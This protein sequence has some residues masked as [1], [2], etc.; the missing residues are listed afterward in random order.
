M[1]FHLVLLTLR[2]ILELAVFEFWNACS[3]FGLVAERLVDRCRTSSR[4]RRVSEETICRAVN[5][6]A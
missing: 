2:A 1:T 6:A 3:G 4:S 5:L